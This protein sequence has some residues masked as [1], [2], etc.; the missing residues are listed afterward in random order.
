MSN[1]T[2]VAFT[3]PAIKWITPSHS[4]NQGFQDHL[5]EA[6]MASDRKRAS[7]ANKAGEDK[8]YR[9]IA[10][11][12]RDTATQKTVS[13]NSNHVSNEML[14]LYIAQERKNEKS[15]RGRTL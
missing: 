4:S 5:N 11:Q 13:S 2:E 14:N 10:D 6:I 7:N 9:L 12:L 8:S 3:T 1:I 15:G